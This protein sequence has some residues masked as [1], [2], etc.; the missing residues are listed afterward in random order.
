MLISYK[1]SFSYVQYQTNRMLHLYKKFVKIYI[2]NII[3][4]SRTLLKYLIRLQKIFE[5]FR[6]K[7]VSLTF[8]KFFLSYSLIFRINSFDIII[9]KKKIV[10]IILLRFSINLKN[11]KTFLKFID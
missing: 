7:Y 9:A 4:Y 5:L 3:V 1:N 11:L 6:L 10:I 8:I 2:N